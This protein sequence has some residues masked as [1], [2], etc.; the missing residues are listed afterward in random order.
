MRRCCYFK[1][2]TIKQHTGLWDWEE[3]IATTSFSVAKHPLEA[4]I[5]QRENLEGNLGDS[6]S[7]S[8]VTWTR[9]E[10]L[11]ELH[12][13]NL[14]IYIQIYID[15]HI[16]Y[17]L[18]QYTTLRIHFR[19]IS[20]PFEEKKPRVWQLH[21]NVAKSAQ[22]IDF[23][24]TK[25]STAPPVSPPYHMSLDVI[26]IF[27]E[28]KKS[29][30][31]FCIFHTIQNSHLFQCSN[32]PLLAPKTIHL[33]HGPHEI[34]FAHSWWIQGFIYRILLHMLWQKH[35]VSCL[36]RRR[37]IPLLFHRFTLTLIPLCFPHWKLHCF[38]EG[39][40]EMAWI[41]QTSSI[42]IVTAEKCVCKYLWIYN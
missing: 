5:L 27:W 2:E 21:Y 36:E 20:S 39:A 7:D 6:G 3:A 31:F 16:P 35:C 11:G 1:V 19:I 32:V 8:W 24:Q 10:K 15:K 22:N 40:E 26:S 25:S 34:D 4:R 42:C 18:S 12:T 33:K 13:Y 14:R 23:I 37:L 28:S 30:W 29:P 17:K 38:S 9:L 41:E